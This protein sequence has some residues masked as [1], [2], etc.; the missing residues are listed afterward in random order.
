MYFSIYVHTLADTEDA[1]ET[2]MAKLE[3]EF[4]ELKEQ[5][6]HYHLTTFHGLIKSGCIS[7]VPGL[8]R[9]Q[10]FVSK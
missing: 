8:L 10:D 1:S 6:V 2:D 3:E 4:S 7:L 9:P 5:L